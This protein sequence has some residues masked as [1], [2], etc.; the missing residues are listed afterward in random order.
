MRRIRRKSHIPLCF[1]FG[2]ALV[3]C[4]P[5]VSKISRN[6]NPQVLSFGFSNS[7]VEVHW[8][9]PSG[10]F[11]KYEL[12]VCSYSEER[13]TLFAQFECELRFGCSVR[14]ELGRRRNQYSLELAAAGGSNATSTYVFSDKPYAEVGKS[15]YLRIRAWQ[16]GKAGPWKSAK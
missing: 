16:N 3:A 13:C 4:A 15:A 14:D 9:V 5:K 7:P 11:A 12:E 1:A 6:D 2:A 10:Q 8:E